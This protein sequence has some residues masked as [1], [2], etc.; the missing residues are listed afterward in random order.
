M[1]GSNFFSCKVPGEGLEAFCFFHEPGNE[2][3]EM[4]TSCVRMG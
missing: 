1:C 2:L 4:R 3:Y